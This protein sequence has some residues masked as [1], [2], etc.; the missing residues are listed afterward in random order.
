MT[1]RNPKQ[2]LENL[3]NQIKNKNNPQR[4]IK[5]GDDEE[6]QDNNVENKPPTNAEELEEFRRKYH[7][8]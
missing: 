4:I 1:N 5:A 8:S 3:V 7:K 6:T 2:E